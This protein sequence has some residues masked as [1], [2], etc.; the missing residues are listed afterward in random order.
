MSLFLKQP[1]EN[2]LGNGSVE[3]DTIEAIRTTCER[4]DGKGWVLTQDGQI[5]VEF[6]N[7]RYAEKSTLQ[8]RDNFVIAA[9][10]FVDR[11]E[12]LL[13]GIQTAR[14]TKELVPLIEEIGQR[15][16]VLRGAG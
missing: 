2:C 15:A 4:C 7:E 14:A 1:C 3:D 9:L 13:F 10:A 6:L 16:R 5:L 12:S 8:N 11:V